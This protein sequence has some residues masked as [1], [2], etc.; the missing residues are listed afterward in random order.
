MGDDFDLKFGDPTSRSSLNYDYNVRPTSDAE[1]GPLLF[2]GT[3]YN[4]GG[5]IT[6]TALF[7]AAS[8]LFRC[9]F[10]YS[11][12]SN[13]YCINPPLL[14]LTL[15]T[16]DDFFACQQQQLLP[17]PGL[18]QQPVEQQPMQQQVKLEQQQQQAQ[19]HRPDA[20]ETSM[21]MAPALGVTPPDAAVCIIDIEMTS[22]NK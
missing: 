12:L 7:A 10:L 9:F 2:N 1:F 6:H 14:T 20:M 22:G 4:F 8:S 16:G 18:T 19:M 13:L 3:S 5:T 21:I 17:D 11:Q 15:G